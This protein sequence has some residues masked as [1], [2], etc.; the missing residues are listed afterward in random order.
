MEGMA[1]Y[2]YFQSS[3]SF[4]GRVQNLDIFLI[5]QG[6]KQ[7]PQQYVTLE[8]LEAVAHLSF[9]NAEETREDKKEENEH[10]HS[11]PLGC[12]NMI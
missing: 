11:S 2:C 4:P 7:A 8:Y 5:H 3:I 10:A 1:F 12:W 9:S 6:K